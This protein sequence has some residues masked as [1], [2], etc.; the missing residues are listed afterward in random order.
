VA[1]TTVSILQPH[2]APEKHVSNAGIGIADG[3]GRPCPGGHLLAPPF[4][5]CFGG[6]P[7]IVYTVPFA[8]A[9]PLTVPSTDAVPNSVPSVA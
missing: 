8:D 1:N 9:C 4:P 7:V 5:Q 2:P 3:K 6:R